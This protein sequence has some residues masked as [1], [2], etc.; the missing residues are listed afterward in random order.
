M[1]QDD[2][3]TQRD[4]SISQWAWIVVG[5]KHEPAERLSPRWQSHPPVT[6]PAAAASRA[7]ALRTIP[8]RVSHLFELK[9]K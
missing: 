8:M 9:P 3:Y 2:T 6:G 4:S 5:E 7:T 1:L